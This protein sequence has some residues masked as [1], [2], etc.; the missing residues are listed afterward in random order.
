VALNLFKAFIEAKQD[1]YAKSD[2]LYRSSLMAAFGVL[3]MQRRTFGDD[4]FPYAL[5]A[6]RRALQTLADYMVERG[7]LREC[8]SVDEIFAQTTRG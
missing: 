1:G 8:P 7:L 3:E 4:P 2:S 5:P 6:N